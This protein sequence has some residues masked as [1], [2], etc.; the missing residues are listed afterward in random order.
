MRPAKLEGG[1]QKYA[2]VSAQEGT[3]A[4]EVPTLWSIGGLP[5][6][7]Q[8]QQT[9]GIESNLGKAEV[10]YSAKIHLP[11]VLDGDGR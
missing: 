5:E 7:Q 6:C 8:L 3:I 2:Q 1:Y 9:A 11:E 4:I 10:V